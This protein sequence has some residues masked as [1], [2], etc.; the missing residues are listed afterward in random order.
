MDK[1]SYSTV[2]TTQAEPDLKTAD[3]LRKL[4]WMESLS[5]AAEL[6]PSPLSPDSSTSIW[7]LYMA[8]GMACAHIVTPAQ[9]VTLLRLSIWGQSS[10]EPF[11]STFQ[12]R[13]QGWTSSSIWPAG[14]KQAAKPTSRTSAIA[15]LQH[16]WR[17]QHPVK[18]VL[19]S[20]VHW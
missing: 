16:S 7:T 6:P 8:E 13:P 11:C 20:G 19:G 10:T 17:Q 4:S 14:H 1:P 18:R 12:H 15:T 3:V 2:P 9:L 5:T